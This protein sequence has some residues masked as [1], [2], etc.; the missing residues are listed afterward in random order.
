MTTEPGT[1]L[2]TGAL[3]SARVRILAWMLL[4]VGITLGVTTSAMAVVLTTQLEER[5]DV[6]LAEEVSEFRK[7]V[8]SHAEMSAHP[9][10]SVRGLLESAL[11]TVVPDEHQTFL[12]LVDGSVLP[13]GEA[14]P[15]GDL[16]DDPALRARLVSADRPVYGDAMTEAGRV[17]YAVVPVAVASDSARGTF[18]VVAY[19]DQERAEIL[20]AVRTDVL[21]GFGALLMAA[22]VGWLFAGRLLAPLRLLRATAN[23]ITESDLARRIP[24]RGD[25]EIT[26]LAETFNRM[27]DRL[28]EAFSTQRRFLD[29][30]GHELRTPITIIRGNLELVDADPRARRARIELVT[31]E[32]DRMSRMVEDLLVLA[33]ANRPDFLLPAPIEVSEVVEEV[34]VKASALADRTW[35]LDQPA[36]A[37][38]AVLHADRQRITQALIQLAQNAVQHTAPDSPIW[39]GS[40]VD[41]RV[42]RIWVRDSGPGVPPDQQ[43]HVFDRFARATRTRHSQGAGLGLAIVKAIAEAHAGRVRLHNRPGAGATFVLELPIS[44]SVPTSHSQVPR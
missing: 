32:L 17:R 11:R 43:D 23:S 40:D 28:Q 36:D 27:L 22:V 6:R 3:Q 26:Q 14:G 9:V 35:L 8:A 21:I 30:A 13:P 10:T 7:Y 1:R 41:G 34:F 19:P 37:P 2:R 42:A 39:I 38:P 24:L 33:T 5:V 4:L 15:G 25:D 44:E 31:D 16:L 18:V 20:D 29:D 12:A